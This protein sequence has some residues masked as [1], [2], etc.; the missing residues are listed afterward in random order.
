[1]RGEAHPQPAP[2]A[3]ESQ[4]TNMQFA[5]LSALGIFFVV[6]G[7]LNNSFFDIGGLLPY[8]SFHM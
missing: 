6:D 7:H 8:Y 4:P 1:M 2:S 5:L 3:A